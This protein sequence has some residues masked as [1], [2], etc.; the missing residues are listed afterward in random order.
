MWLQAGTKHMISDPKFLDAQR[1]EAAALGLFV[2]ALVTKAIGYGGLV[3]MLL[4]RWAA[5]RAP[6]AT[7][8]ACGAIQPLDDGMRLACSRCARLLREDIAVPVA[9]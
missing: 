4:S 1:G 3:L 2:E 7:C 9:A 5:R 6:R 8:S